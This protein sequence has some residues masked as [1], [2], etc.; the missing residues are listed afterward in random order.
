MFSP[1]R[2]KSSD[3]RLGRADA[4]GNFRLGD[5]CGG[6]S[7]EKFVEELEFFIQ[8][9]IFSLYVRALKGVRFQLFMSEHF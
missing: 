7:L 2:F 6:P 1:S 3:R 5:S 4:L 9:I 8:L